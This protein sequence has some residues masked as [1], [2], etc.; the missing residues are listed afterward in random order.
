MTQDE[1]WSI[2]YKEVV[3]SIEANHLNP[4]K[5][6]VEKINGKINISNFIDRLV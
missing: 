1:K 4:S 6:R 2:R 5:H 3:G